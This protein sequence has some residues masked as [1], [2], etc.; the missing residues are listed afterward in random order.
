ELEAT[1]AELGRRTDIG[2]LILLS[3]KEGTF[4]AGADV[5]LIA[6][7]TDLAVA[8]QGC[9]YGQG[10]FAAWESL[11]FPTVAAIRGTC[12]GGGTELAL[13]STY[14]VVSDRPETK[15]G[16]PEVRLGILPGWGGCT[17]LPRLV[18]PVAALDMILTGKN[19][20]AQRAFK[21]GLA[22]AL[23]P[24]GA[25]LSLARDFALARRDRK[26]TEHRARSLQQT[27]L[28]GNPL[29]RA[30]V[31][32]QARKKTLA[33]TKGQYPAPIRALET[34]R[35]GLER[36]RAAGFAAEAK[37]AAEL[38][39]SPI[40]KNLVHVFKL[41]EAA[42]KAGPK[43]SHEPIPPREVLVLGA[44]VMGGGIAQLV[45]DSA[46][47]PVRLKDVN[48]RGLEHGL[49]HAASL[50]KKQ[51]DRR[52]MSRAEARRKMALLRPT[53]A[54]TGY[55]S[56]DLMIEAVVENLEIKQKVFADVA[57][58]TGEKT[59][60]AS[61]TSSLSIDAIGTLTPHR[62][63][64]VGMHF[65]NPVDK[66]PLVEVIQGP[67]TSPEAAAA[68]YSFC[69]RLGKTPVLVQDGPG[70]LVN[71]LLMFY[72]CEALWLLDEGHKIEDLDLAM[73]RWGMPMGPLALNDEVGL[74]VAV[75]VAH[76]L[77]EA[78]A[79]R[80]PLPPWLDR[81]SGTGRLGAKT[82]SGFYRYQGKERTEPDPEVYR[83]L[84]IQ[85]KISNPSLESLA[86]RMVLPMVNEASRCLA[87]GIVADAGS[88]DL[89][90]IMGTGFPPF[91]GGLCRWADSVGLPA[92]I[93][94]L[95]RLAAS[96]GKR[97]EP[98]PALREAALQGGFYASWP[99]R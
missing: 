12:V 2:C 26:R 86:E 66:M 85:P 28:E 16:L 74:D 63:R 41:M 31:F 49:A 3:G 55:Q 19:I 8:E 48:A 18:G 62:D 5:N 81:V 75:K 76:I 20:P 90:M 23:L 35:T 98:A 40:S 29:G 33:E 50:F 65:F 67:R 95:E 43:A 52:R 38:A 44:G 6:E 77:A 58:R 70:F 93:E 14:R 27:L 7:V 99:A 72:A 88:L 37:G 64:V 17:R 84:G 68:V 34:V 11:P 57:G 60:L 56:V 53:L 10:V 9:R 89:A 59:V 32:S 97:F 21:M 61:N 82:G 15:I 83:L 45:A 46:D 87:E 30:L 79:D 22:D 51:V 36:G 13:A 80:L 78:F 96:A 1:I 94:S 25:F 71:R 39:I 4:I 47:V 91:R 42:K 73:T 69:R 54:D 24:E 92:L